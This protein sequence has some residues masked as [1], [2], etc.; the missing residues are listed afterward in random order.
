MKT[1]INPDKNSWSKLLE[2]PIVV[3][4]N[5]KAAMGRPPENILEII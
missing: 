4:N 5:K 3:V 1:Y 2:R